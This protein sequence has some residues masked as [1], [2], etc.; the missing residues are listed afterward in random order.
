MNISNTDDTRIGTVLNGRYRIIERI[1]TGGMAVVYRGERVELGRPVAIK[2]LQEVILHYPKFIGRFEGEAKAM[3]KL[4]HPYCVSVMDF[5][6]DGAPYIVMDYVEGKTLK[7]V[8]ESETVAPARAIKIV[9]QVLAGIAHAHSH[10]IIHRDLKPGNVLLQN[11]VGVGESVRIFDFGL[12]KLTDA[13]SGANMSI[14]LMAGTPNYMSPEQ[15]RGKKV[16]ERT[17]LY[18][19]GVMLFELLSGEKPFSHEDYLEV[20]RMHRRPWRRA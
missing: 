3:S 20:V 12:A 15:S 8:L 9:R 1:G 2:F 6:V 17:D 5:G 10:G 18:A 11:M 13:A 14:S 4:S 16:D 19:I 7:D